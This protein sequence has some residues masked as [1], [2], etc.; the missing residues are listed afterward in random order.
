LKSELILKNFLDRCEPEKRKKLEKHLSADERLRIEKLPSFEGEATHENF[1]NGHLVEKVHWSWFLPTLKTYPEEEQKL[2]LAAVDSNT[3]KSL[4]KELNLLARPKGIS[5]IGRSYMRQILLDSLLGPNDRL[6]PPDFLPPSP[7]KSLLHLSKKELIQLIDRLALYDLSSEIRQIV[8]TKILKKIYSLLSTEEMA[9][10]KRVGTTEPLPRM[11]ISWDGTE[12]AFRVALHKRGI[13]RLGLALSGQ[14]PD[15]IWY[16]CHQLDI[17]RGTALFKH[18]A[19]EAI[20]GATDHAIK[21]IGE[22]T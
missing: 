21:Q 9:F 11:L 17:G 5:E 4:A 20:P 16:I 1:G 14:N 12:E 10:L 2:F 19:K 8:E 15:L 18:C 3:S 22:I 13:A 7:L 6:L